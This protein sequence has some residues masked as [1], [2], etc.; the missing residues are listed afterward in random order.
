MVSVTAN[1]S[2]VITVEYNTNALHGT[3]GVQINPG[4]S[5][6]SSHATL[7]AFVQ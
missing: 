5:V 3:T 6:N 4:G 1:S 2:N 7:T